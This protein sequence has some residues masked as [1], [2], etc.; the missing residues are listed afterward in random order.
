MK[1]FNTKFSLIKF[2]L[3]FLF[4]STIQKPFVF[5]QQTVELEDDF[6]QAID[7]EE[8]RLKWGTEEFKQ[9][10]IKEMSTANVSLFIDEHLQKITEPSRIYYKFTK[11]FLFVK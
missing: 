7:A 4:F 8:K 10:L 11:D 1:Q 6:S 5:A 3:L 9:E 2:I